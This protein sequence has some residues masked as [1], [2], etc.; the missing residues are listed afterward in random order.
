M[1]LL[2]PARRQLTGPCIRSNNRAQVTTELIASSR[3]G[4]GSSMLAHSR[5]LATRAVFIK[6]SDR[7]NQG[8]S[9]VVAPVWVYV[10]ERP[11]CVRPLATRASRRLIRSMG[12]SGKWELLP[13]LQRRKYT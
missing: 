11:S 7:D 8:P 12:P 10:K 6:S 1:A 3:P 9:L 13:S 4:S 5:R 2:I